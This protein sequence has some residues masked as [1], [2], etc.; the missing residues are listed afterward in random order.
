MT[1]DLLAC[2]ELRANLRITLLAQPPGDRAGEDLGEW[3][4]M[5]CASTVNIVRSHMKPLPKPNRHYS[6]GWSPEYLV[7]NRFLDTLINIRR[8]LTGQAGRY[9]WPS[10]YEHFGVREEIDKLRSFAAE[11]LRNDEQRVRVLHTTGTAPTHWL[12][13]PPRQ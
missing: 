7:L 1:N 5:I 4:E 6:D 2:E 13:T 8:H 10:D 3:I 12:V 9:K 11:T